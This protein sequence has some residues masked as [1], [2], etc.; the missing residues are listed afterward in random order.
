MN[1]F[2]VDK[3][4][5][6]AAQSL[7]D[8]H[9]PKMIVESVQM[10]VSAIRRHGADDDGVPWTVKGTPHKGGYRNHPATVWAGDS[11]SNFD[12]LLMHGFGLCQEYTFRFGKEHSCWSQLAFLQK[13]VELVPPG[14][15]TDVALCVGETFQN[16]VTHAPMQDAVSVYRRFYRADKARFAVW[17]RGRPAPSWWIG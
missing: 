11:D 10:L 8:K 5:F 2:V 3:N 1:I 12:W 4:P 13:R 9:V 7:C 15:L 14:P 16:G 17:E 6:V